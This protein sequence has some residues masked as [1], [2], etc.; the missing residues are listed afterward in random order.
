MKT[1]LKSATEMIFESSTFDMIK[2]EHGKAKIYKL[3]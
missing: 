1:V 2:L 3:L